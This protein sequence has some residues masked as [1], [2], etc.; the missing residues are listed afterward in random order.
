M[1][2]WLECLEV[3]STVSAVAT[4]W[5]GEQL[6]SEHCNCSTHTH[7][8]S[9]THAHTHPPSHTPT[10]THFVVFPRCKSPPLVL[11]T[12]SVIVRSRPHPYRLLRHVHAESGA[13]RLCIRILVRS[14]RDTLAL[15]LSLPSGLRA[16]RVI[17]LRQLG[18]CSIAYAG[19]LAMLYVV[20][21]VWKQQHLQPERN[22]HG[23]DLKA[24]MSLSKKF[25]GLTVPM[26][27]QCPQ[28]APRAMF[29]ASSSDL[30]CLSSQSRTVECAECR[31]A[32]SG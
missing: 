8:P 19:Q 23:L 2:C 20:V 4:F 5:T 18:L 25:V 21:F 17:L 6:A 14:Q 27:A 10:N 32:C 7:P 12:A 13:G 3:V 28:P 16:Y 29:P 24:A 22:W 26:A 31:R 9:H 15:S 1:T 30:C 11:K